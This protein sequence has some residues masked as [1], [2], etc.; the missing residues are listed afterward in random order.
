MA[1][2]LLCLGDP[3]LQ[4]MDRIRRLGPATP[5]STKGAPEDK[6]GLESRRASSVGSPGSESSCKPCG[7]VALGLR[8]GCRAAGLLW[9]AFHPA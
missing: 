6:P 2:G 8:V 7:G 9:R 1:F 4:L 5:P 3:R